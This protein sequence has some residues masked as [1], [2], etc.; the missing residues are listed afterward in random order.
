MHVFGV[1]VA[2][3]MVLKDN[4]PA[5]AGNLLESPGHDLWYTRRR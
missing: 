3:G 1:D 2:G 5:R 4:L